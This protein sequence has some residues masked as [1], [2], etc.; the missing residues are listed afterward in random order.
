MYDACITVTIYAVLSRAFLASESSILTRHCC[1]LNLLFAGLRVWLEEF[2]TNSLWVPFTLQLVSPPCPPTSCA[3]RHGAC[4]CRDKATA[5]HLHQHGGGGGEM[6]LEITPAP[7]QVGSGSFHNAVSGSPTHTF[8]KT[9]L[10]VS[11]AQLLLC[12]ISKIS[13]AFSAMGKSKKGDTGGK[14]KQKLNFFKFYQNVWPGKWIDRVS[15]WGRKGVRG[16]DAQAPH[17]SC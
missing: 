9:Q 15:P 1:E 16:T 14:K 4:S 12:W 8:Q 17:T 7:V 3:E 5:W 2:P 11:S 13:L 6:F 10:D